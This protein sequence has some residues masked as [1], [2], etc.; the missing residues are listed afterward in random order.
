MFVAKVEITNRRSCC[1]KT[2]T[3]MRVLLGNAS[4]LCTRLHNVF[5]RK[6]IVFVCSQSVKTSD[7]T[8]QIVGE[9]RTLT[10]CE[11]RV[12]AFG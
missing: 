6:S 5:L 3:N 4:A 1:L 8:I 12:T 10:L 2:D 11:V 9:N 7:V